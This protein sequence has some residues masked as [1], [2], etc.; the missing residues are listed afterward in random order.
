MTHEMKNVNDKKPQK[1]RLV[2]MKAQNKN[3]LKW[4]M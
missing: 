4:T 3:Y 2:N 1:T